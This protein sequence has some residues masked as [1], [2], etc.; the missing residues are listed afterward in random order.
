MFKKLSIKARLIATMTLMG[1]MLLIGGAMS[2]VSLQNANGAL[3][4][5]YSNQLASA[6][7]IGTS[8]VRL[9]QA[10][11]TLDRAMLRIDA[12]DVDALTKRA[13]DF[14]AQS[15]KEWE[16]Y[17]ALPVEN[18]EKKLSDDV[19]A[20][21]AAY[22]RGG[23]QALV[24]AI[25]ARQRDEAERVMFEKIQPLS[26]ALNQSADALSEYQIKSAEDNY[27]ASQATFLAFRT[28][29]I[30]CVLAGLAI[31]ALSAFFLVRA[32]T[33]PLREMLGH[34]EAIAGGDLTGRIEQRSD[35]EMGRLMGG[36]GKMQGSLVDTVLHV[37]QGSATIGDATE[38][39]AAGNLD[40]S[41][42]TEQ[43]ASSLEETASSME[44]LTST[45]KQ[46]AD[47][48]RQAN[49]LV[50]SAVEVAVKG[51]AV[52][53]QVV[54]TMGAINDSSRKVVDIIG[55]IDG[56]AFQTNILALNAA[57]EA[58]RAGEQ[59]RGFAVVASEVRTLAQR[60]AAA[61][62]EIKMLIDDSV[63][64]VDVG[65]RLVDQAGA[66]MQEIVDSVRRVTDIM[67]EISSASQ[68]QTSG[69]EQINQAIVQMDQ[70]TQQ[71]A[72][73]VE[74]AAAAAESLKE[75]AA[76]LAQA[77]GVFKLDARLLA[78]PA[79]PAIGSRARPG[80]RAAAPARRL[81]S[82]PRAAVKPAP[83]KDEWEQF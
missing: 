58:A 35:D 76:G 73:L 78:A 60:S 12:P 32:I 65:A 41:S 83:A 38:Q 52:V 26:A 69:I 17:L 28:T 56:I 4:E 20:K 75:Q 57:V 10:R 31:V 64:K 53:A 81:A 68:E 59:G 34:F 79:S 24:A 70:V 67:S 7:A 25:R 39:I 55:V 18:D 49:G 46:N 19:S 37:Q 13:E 8:Q 11:T 74:E 27:A 45:V 40:L 14:N 6:I 77:V 50:Q 3:K 9:F 61:A 5:M 29:A 22:M 62:K 44:E 47:N 21:R 43:Q 80:P 16:K 30:A 63:G 82:A 15:E 23:A 1:F 71:N 33:G 48:A 72:A 42:R 2:I 51:G 36:L 54:D 66:T